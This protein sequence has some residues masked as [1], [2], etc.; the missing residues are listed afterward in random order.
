MPATHSAANGSIAVTY[1]YGMYP[2]RNMKASWI[3]S[4]IATTRRRL[5]KSAGNAAITPAH[6]R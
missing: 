5:T 3:S 6:S 2:F 4:S 1:A